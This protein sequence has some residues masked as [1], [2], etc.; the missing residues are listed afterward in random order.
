MTEF[1]A[2]KSPVAPPLSLESFVG[3]R[4]KFTN[5]KDASFVGHLTKINGDELDFQSVVFLGPEGNPMATAPFIRYPKSAINSVLPLQLAEVLLTAY[6]D[7]APLPP[8]EIEE[9][10]A[11]FT[12]PT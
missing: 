5:L 1:E 4:A 12:R 3:H 8:K 7:R 9:R 6:P 2:P 10:M 11:R